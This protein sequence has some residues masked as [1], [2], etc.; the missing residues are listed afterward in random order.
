[1]KEETKKK[2]NLWLQFVSSALQ[3]LLLLASKEPKCYDSSGGK[4]TAKSKLVAE[5]TQYFILYYYYIWLWLLYKTSWDLG[6]WEQQP[7]SEADGGT[8]NM[9]Q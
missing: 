9:Q 8:M 5:R 1:M 4:L 7:S 2:E 6:G 3:L